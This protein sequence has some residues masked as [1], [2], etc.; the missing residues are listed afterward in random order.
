MVPRGYLR[1][2]CGVL[3]G[4]LCLSIANAQPPSDPWVTPAN[5]TAPRSLEP[6]AFASG[7]GGGVAPKR[8]PARESAG[9][10]TPTT[11]SNLSRASSLWGTVAALVVIAAGVLVAGK[12]I[13]RHGPA[14]LRP[15]PDVALEP[16]GQ[17][18]LSRGVAVHLVRCGGQ[19][20]L[21]GVGPDGI[22]T[23]STISDP[24]EVELLAAAC[25]RRDESLL[26]V[27]AFSQ[28]LQRQ[29]TSAAKSESVPGDSFPSVVGR[30]VGSITEVDGV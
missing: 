1:W 10:A 28:L 7:E 29:S 5:S 25:R 13:R 14:V 15:L 12:W 19:M 8:L 24:E 6:T 16:L 20:L 23:L 11:K 17:R 9:Q 26:K 4:L 2:G 22:R 21:L 27:T 3:L 18:V 30:S